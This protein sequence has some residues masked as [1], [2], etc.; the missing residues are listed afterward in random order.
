V[1]DALAGTTDSNR[2]ELWFLGPRQVELR[3][4]DPPR[5]LAPGEVQV[6]ALHSGISQGTELLLYRGQGP[7]IFD[8]SLDAPDVPIYP[9]RYGY[10]WVGRIV[11]SRA[12]GYAPGAPVFALQPHAD[13]HCLRADQVRLLPPDIPSPR[14]TLAANLETA[15]T[16][17]WDAG[18]ALGDDVVVVGG[19]IVGLLCV[20]LA[21][22]AGAAQVRLVEPSEKRREAGR[23]LGADRAEAPDHDTPEGD[24]DVV[25]EATGD[26]AVLDRA[27]AHAGFEAT[28]ALASFY[29]E[30]R[31]PIGLGDAFHRKRLTLKSSQVSHLPARRT[32][33][34]DLARRFA[35]VLDYLHDPRLDALVDVIAPFVEAPALYARLDADP[36][37]AL[38][39]VLSYP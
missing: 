13:T 15:L 11:H 4:A 38:H 5:P 2:R 19:G 34:W 12:Q 1:N 20:L 10:A 35:R 7:R 16:V 3:L 8:P 32:P 27:I 33:R 26:P 30:R 21:K 17:V 28:I 25:I 39:S 22:R 14:A 18:I 36:G 31:S 37:A 29:G 9:R 6:R 24:A 23:R